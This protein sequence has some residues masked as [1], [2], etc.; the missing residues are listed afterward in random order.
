MIEPR[1][2]CFFLIRE[3]PG[4]K[5][6]QFTMC[7]DQKTCQERMKTDGFRAFEFTNEMILDQA[8]DIV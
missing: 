4:T 5:D 8:A 7:F 3:V 1:S 6:V 2:P